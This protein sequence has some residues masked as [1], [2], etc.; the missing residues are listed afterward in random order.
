MLILRRWERM[1][2]IL[3]KNDILCGLELIFFKDI[4]KVDEFFKC[5]I[6]IEIGGEVDFY[7]FFIKN[8]EV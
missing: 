1:F 2:K 3:N 7:L 6:Y 4:I 5:Y 8:E